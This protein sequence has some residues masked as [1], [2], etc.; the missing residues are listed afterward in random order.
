[1][2][3]INCSL[4]H[5]ADLSDSNLRVE[6]LGGDNEDAITPIIHSRHDGMLQDSKQPNT[7]DNVEP[8]VT[9]IINPEELIRR[10]FLM[11]KQDDGQQFCA[12]IVKLIDDHTSL[13]ENDKERIKL[14]LSLDNDTREEVITYNQ[15]LDYLA[16]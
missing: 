16:K 8:T 3:V 10:T 5:P 1:M 14:L 2:K 9:P 11:G 15:L 13:L 4:I 7:Q 6:S 12:R